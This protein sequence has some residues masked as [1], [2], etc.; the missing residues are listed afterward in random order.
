MTGTKIKIVSLDDSSIPVAEFFMSIC[1]RPKFI[2]SS[3]D[4]VPSLLI[5]EN[6]ASYKSNFYKNSM[7]WIFYQF[8]IKFITYLKVKGK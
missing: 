3:D 8:Q 2:C 4:G 7:M 1:S 5:T 6:D